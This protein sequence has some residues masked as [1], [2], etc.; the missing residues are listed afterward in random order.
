MLTRHKKTVGGHALAIVGYNQRGFW[1]QNSWGEEWGRNGT[2]LWTYEDWLVNVYDAWVFRMALPTPRIWALPARAGDKSG[3]A[4]K[5]PAPARAEIAG[6]FVHV[7]DG[8]FHDT[9]RYWSTLDD[10]PLTADLVANSDDYEHVLFYAHGG[11]NSPDASAR[12]IA[13]MT[14]T[15]KANCIYPYHSMCD[16]GLLEELEDVIIG[17]RQQADARAAG[18]TDWI[19]TIIEKSFR[20]PGRALWREMKAGAELPFDDRGAG[21]GPFD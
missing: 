21:S 10:V 9:G 16:T 3:V 11:P 17:R 5:S 7:D 6:H 4:E 15:F 20:V 8:Y 14:E 1:I 19:D 12:R 2:A 18:I 13:A